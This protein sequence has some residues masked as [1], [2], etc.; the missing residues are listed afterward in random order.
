M[1][2]KLRTKSVG[3]YNNTKVKL[4]YYCKETI[5]QSEPYSTQS[6]FFLSGNRKHGLTMQITNDHYNP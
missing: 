2:L 5:S 6:I 1:G 3:L 4:H